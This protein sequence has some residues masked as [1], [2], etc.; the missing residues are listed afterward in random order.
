M[1]LGPRF[2]AL[3]SAKGH[4]AVS[5]FTMFFASGLKLSPEPPAIAPGHGLGPLF[6]DLSE[7]FVEGTLYQST[8]V[9]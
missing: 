2:P 9:H 1:L 3:V 7:I 6:E 8:P 5:A 4:Q